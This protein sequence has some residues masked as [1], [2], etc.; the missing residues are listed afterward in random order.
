MNFTNHSRKMITT[1]GETFTI[2]KTGRNYFGI[3][4][5]E[6]VDTDQ[7]SGFSPVITCMTEDAAGLNRGDLIKYGSGLYVF[8]LE[9]ADGTGVS[10]LILETS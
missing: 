2:Q 7:I 6:Y 4:D 1:M 3:F 10:R 5:K 8:I 9:E